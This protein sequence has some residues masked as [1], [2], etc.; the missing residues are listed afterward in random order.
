MHNKIPILAPCEDLN[1][2]KF[3]GREGI[4][5][6]FNNSSIWDEND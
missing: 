3:S 5:L 1:R 6:A 2:Q 4:L